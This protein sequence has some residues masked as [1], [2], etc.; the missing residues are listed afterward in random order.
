MKFNKNLKK[1]K[2]NKLFTNS[3]LNKAT[4]FFFFFLLNFICLYIN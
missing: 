1:K 2:F 4:F 3:F